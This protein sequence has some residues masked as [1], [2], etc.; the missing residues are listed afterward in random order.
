MK[1][2]KKI[3]LLILGMVLLAHLNYPEDIKVSFLSPKQDR[4]WIG[5]LPVKIEIKGVKQERIRSVEVYLD[6]R[7]LREMKQPPYDFNHNFGK[8]PK[9]RKLRIIIRGTDNLLLRKEINSYFFDDSHD[10]DV[11]QIVV[12]VNVIDSRGNYVPGMEKD[13]FILLEDGVSQKINY[14]NIKGKAKFNL[15]LLVDI[16]SSMKDK[17]GKVKEAAKTFLE[18]LL[19]RNDKAMILLFNHEVF[20]EVEFTNDLDEL[21]NSLSI[22]FPFGATAMYDAIAY[23]IR[24][25]KGV[26]GRNI[27]ILFSDGEDNSSFIDPYT[28][29]KKA[30]RSNSVIYA[31]GKSSSYYDAQY[32]SLLKKISQ[33]SG[34]LSLFLDNV[35]EIKMVYNRIRHDIR[36]QYILQFSPKKYGKKRS[37][38]KIAV[39]LRDKRKKYSI[40]TIK[41]YF[42]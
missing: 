22:T 23:C 35:D 32:Q 39:K 24:L 19:T 38:R 6:G 12:P 9:N 7:L 28:L 41:G 4:I 13:D 15:V 29:I 21:Y 33:S 34:G 17:I 27:I 5:T 30:E 3:F 2:K 8:T 10:V 18:K 37:F 20:E 1:K 31:I 40:R 25:L 26:T 11:F 14:F 16:S 36:S 42:Y